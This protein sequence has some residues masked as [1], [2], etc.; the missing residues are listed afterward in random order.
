MNK[1]TVHVLTDPKGAHWGLVIDDVK[2]YHTAPVAVAGSSYPTTDEAQIAG[3]N[4]RKNIPGGFSMPRTY[5][6][7]KALPTLFDE[8]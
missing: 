4:V 5:D 6:V 1:L 2:A 3:E 8:N 7:S